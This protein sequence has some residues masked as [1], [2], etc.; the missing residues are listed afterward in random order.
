LEEGRV[1]CVTPVE[2]L[3][4]TVLDDKRVT[5]YVTAGEEKC[6]SPRCRAKLK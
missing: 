4:K 6:K 2:L 5:I 3:L 1:I